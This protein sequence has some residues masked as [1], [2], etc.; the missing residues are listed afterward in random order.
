M[1]INNREKIWISIIAIL[2]LVSLWQ[3]FE[4]SKLLSENDVLSKN[5]ED[6]SSIIENIDEK[7]T[8]INEENKKTI[9]ANLK[10]YSESISY[11]TKALYKLEEI[12]REQV[13][14]IEEHINPNSLLSFYLVDSNGNLFKDHY[15]RKPSNISDEEIFKFIALYLNE[16]YFEDG[17]IEILGIENK[18]N[19]SILSVNLKEKNQTRKWAELYFQGSTGGYI[20]ET[21]LIESFLQRN[22]DN[23]PIDAVLFL[24]ENHEIEFDHVPNLSSIQY[25]K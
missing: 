6:Y 20:T 17:V 16:N 8:S 3:Q 15:M 25:R 10:A 22:N 7:I 14:I 19:T 4:L 5:I 24:Y 12:L 9:D 1:E 13:S 18:N 11:Y 23:W 21:L 2:V